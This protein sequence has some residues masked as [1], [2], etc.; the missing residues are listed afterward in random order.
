MT[1]WWYGRAQS[2]SL[3]D[4]WLSATSTSA[5][6]S[7]STP[8]SS[9]RSTSSDRARSTSSLD[10]SDGRQSAAHGGPC[11]CSCRR[12]VAL[13]ACARAKYAA[14]Q[15]SNKLSS[16]E[17]RDDIPPPMAVRLAA[18]L[19]PSADGSAVRPSLVAGGGVSG[20]QRAYSLGQL[21]PGIDRRAD[22]GIA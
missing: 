13:R 15:L 17:R 8:G 21:R 22:R 18:D 16:R 11:F 5:G 3:A 20:S 14:S 4:E 9:C 10:E 2:S 19:R 12:R 7:S 6:V 1:S